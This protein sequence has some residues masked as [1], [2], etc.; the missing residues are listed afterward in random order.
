MSSFDPVERDADQGN[1]EHLRSN[2]PLTLHAET[3]ITNLEHEL[4]FARMHVGKA[5]HDLGVLKSILGR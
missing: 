3:L 2:V 4:A 5:E 1:V